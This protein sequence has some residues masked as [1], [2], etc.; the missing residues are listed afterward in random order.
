[1]ATPTRPEL[2]ETGAELEALAPSDGGAALAVVLRRGAAKAGS[3]EPLAA[4]C[5]MLAERAA[6]TRGAAV[7]APRKANA[8]APT[9]KLLAA[10]MAQGRG[11]EMAPA[12]SGAGSGSARVAGSDSSLGAGGTLSFRVHSTK[13]FRAAKVRVKGGVAGVSGPIGGVAGVRCAMG[14]VAGAR[15]EPGDG[16]AKNAC[17]DAAGVSGP[18]LP[19]CHASAPFSRRR[20]RRTLAPSRLATSPRSNGRE[21]SRS[22]R[23][24]ASAS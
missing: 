21:N 4:A 8:T 10:K 3:G 13:S 16:L 23:A 2:G 19:G 14:G 18:L 11:E 5:T 1:M 20:A 7:G 24:S 12:G 22:R 6:L 9:I 17:G 15:S